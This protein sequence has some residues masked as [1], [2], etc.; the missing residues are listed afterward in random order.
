MQP[1]PTLGDAR[2]QIDITA[3]RLLAAVKKTAAA[4]PTRTP[5]RIRVLGDLRSAVYEALNQLP[6]EW[7]A[8]RAR[9]YLV[10]HRPEL[11]NALWSWNPHQTGTSAE[12]DLRA[13]RAGNILASVEVTTSQRPV[14]TI[15]ARMRETLKKLARLKG[16]LYYFVVSPE[17]SQ[18]ART[19]IKKL[20]AHI[21]V[22]ELQPYRED[23]I[24]R[25]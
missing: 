4:A 2:R 14:G 7:L 20:G 25:R 12:P 3:R 16:E 15:D 13:R 19:K 22:V 23:R 11:R 21:E 1:M 18:R 17:M 9:E 24:S 8:L 6:H 10:E 5:E